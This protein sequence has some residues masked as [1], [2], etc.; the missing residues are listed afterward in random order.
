MLGFA[1]MLGFQGKHDYF[2]LMCPVRHPV[3]IVMPFSPSTRYALNKC[4]KSDNRPLE[5][6]DRE[7]R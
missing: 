7:A 6:P 5:S 2:L 3:M 1:N 4:F